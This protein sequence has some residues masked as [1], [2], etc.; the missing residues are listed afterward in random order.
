MQGDR[1]ASEEINVTWCTITQQGHAQLIQTQMETHSRKT[2]KAND[3]E[4][5]EV[6]RSPQPTPENPDQ[7]VKRFLLISSKTTLN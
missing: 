7:F 4:E 3:M 5:H 1:R 6:T 2:V